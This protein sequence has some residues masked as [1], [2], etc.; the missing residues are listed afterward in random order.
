MCPC[1]GPQ[2][3][4]LQ[5]VD[6]LADVGELIRIVAAPSL[7][8]R[9]VGRDRKSSD[10]LS[11]Y[12]RRLGIC[13]LRSDR[14]APVRHSA[15]CTGKLGGGLRI[16]IRPAMSQKAPKIRAG[17]VNRINSNPNRVS[18]AIMTRLFSQ[19]CARSR[20]GYLLLSTYGTLAQ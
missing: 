10:G 1:A 6:H 3:D 2:I 12:A 11:L 8:H 19:K 14:A 20:G 5:V 13:R 17:C 9:L 7:G 18:Q 15:S 16:R 4:V